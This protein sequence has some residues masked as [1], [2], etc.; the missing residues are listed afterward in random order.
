MLRI[1]FIVTFM[2]AAFGV[3]SLEE[4]QVQRQTFRSA[5]AIPQRILIPKPNPQ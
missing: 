4:V 2:I 1:S 3:Q 5:P